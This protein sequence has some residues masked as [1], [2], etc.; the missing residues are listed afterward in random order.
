[1]T[2]CRSG[3]TE[4]SAVGGRCHAPLLE[5][6]EPERKPV[7]AFEQAVGDRGDQLYRE[8]SGPYRIAQ[9]TERAPA[10]WNRY[11]AANRVRAIADLGTRMI[12]FELPDGT[13]AMV[14]VV[15]A[16]ALSVAL[17]ESVYDALEPDGPF[18]SVG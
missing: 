16:R 18:L 11:L 13:R 10:G 3:L 12:S 17:R 6:P 14:D 1:V 4:Y 7:L 9:Q 15:E 2:A 8:K 5:L